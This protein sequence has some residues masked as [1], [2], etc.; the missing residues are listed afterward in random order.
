M[1]RTTHRQKA[2]TARLNKIL[3]AEVNAE[4]EN[5][6]LAMGSESAKLKR[7]T[8]SI[9]KKR[10]Q[11]TNLPQEDDASISKQPK[12][13]KASS[14][15]AV[16]TDKRVDNYG[17]TDL[18][19]DPSAP[20]EM[21]KSDPNKVGTSRKV[22][23]EK[24]KGRKA[25]TSTVTFD[26]DNSFV[27]MEVGETSDHFHSEHEEGQASSSDGMERNSSN[28]EET[29][30]NHSTDNARAEEDNDSPS[31]ASS[32]EEDLPS[33]SSSDS[34]SETESNPAEA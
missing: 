16:K 26:E 14:K 20:N 22:L 12:K 32:S 5:G 10:K 8:C 13:A 4:K 34:E 25:A 9:T 28:N 6:D 7:E 3:T 23:P 19:L 24:D 21:S 2:K 27:T 15:L 11:D 31:D 29:D 1:G 18:D 30:D 17:D 33:D